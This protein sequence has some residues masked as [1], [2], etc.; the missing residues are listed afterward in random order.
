VA[1][2]HLDGAIA[3]PR[4]RLDAGAIDELVDEGGERWC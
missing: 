1:A 2:D 3:M 4:R